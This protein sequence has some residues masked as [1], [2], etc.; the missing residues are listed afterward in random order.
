[1]STE[2]LIDRSTFCLSTGRD[3]LKVTICTPENK[4]K[5]TFIQQ[6]SVEIIK[7]SQIALELSKNKTKEMAGTLHK[8][9]GRKLTIEPNIFSHLSELKDY[10]SNYYNVHNCEFVNSDNQ[11]TL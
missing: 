10:L 11:I 4:L 9:L 6:L 2:N 5:R 7:Q 8:G 3:P 1:M